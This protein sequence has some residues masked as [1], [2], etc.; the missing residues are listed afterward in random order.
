MPALPYPAGEGATCRRRLTGARPRVRREGGGGECWG[1]REGFLGGSLPAHPPSAGDAATAVRL[2]AGTRPRGALG[3]SR[4][5]PKGRVD[6]IV[7]RRAGSC[8]RQDAARDGRGGCP[9]SRDW[10]RPRH[11]PRGRRPHRA[12]P[13]GERTPGQL[14][15]RSGAARRVRRPGT[16]GCQRPVSHDTFEHDPGH[17]RTP[18]TRQDPASP[19]ACTMSSLY[20]LMRPAGI[21]PATSRSGGARSIP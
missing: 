8:H 16:T 19:G 3:E 18:E 9:R 17:A 2:S 21:E 4:G 13:H 14:V 5:A 11:D 1:A 10:N 7:A 12:A 15:S 20:R 6:V